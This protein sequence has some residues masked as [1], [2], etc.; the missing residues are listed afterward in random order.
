MTTITI[1]ASRSKL[2]LPFGRN[3]AHPRN[4]LG[5]SPTLNAQELRRIVAETFG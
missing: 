4:Q 2:S 5:R 3:E 1:G